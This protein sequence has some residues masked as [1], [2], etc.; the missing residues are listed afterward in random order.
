MRQKP[1]RQG[2]FLP[3]IEGALDILHSHD[4]FLSEFGHIALEEHENMLSVLGR[5]DD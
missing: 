4:K 5:H 2:G 1:Y 3:T